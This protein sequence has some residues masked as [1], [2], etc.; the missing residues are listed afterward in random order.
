MSWDDVNDILFTGTPEQ[1]SSVRCPECGGVLKL[2]YFPV[3]KSVEIYCSGCGT[4]IKQHGVSQEPNFA[5]LSA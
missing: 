3:T 5:L 2:S 4:V 1:I